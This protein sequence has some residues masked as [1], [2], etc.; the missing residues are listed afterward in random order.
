MRQSDFRRPRNVTAAPFL[1]PRENSFLLSVVIPCM[2][3]EEVL[4]RTVQQLVSALECG[5]LRFELIFVDDGSTDST[6]EILRELQ[7]EDPRIRIVRLSRNFGH[8]VAITAGLEHAIG[9]A[10][11]IIDADLQDPPDVLLTFI[12]KWVDGYDVVYGVRADRDGETAFKLW[13]AKLFYRLISRLSDTRIPLDTGDFRL[14]DRRVVDAL[15][16]MPE[17]DRFVR[18]MVSWLGFSQIGVAYRRAARFAGATK[19]PLFKMLRFAADAIFS[20]S[21]IPLRLATWTGFFASGLA[22]FGILF[23]IYSRIFGSGLVKGWTSTVIAILFLGGAQLVCLGIIG[24]YAGRIYGECKRRPLYVV[25][26]KIGFEMA[27]RMEARPLQAQAA[28]G[29]R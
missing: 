8:Q 28:M 1:Q 18:G 23:S 19:Y 11:A 4:P 26:E 5:A 10:V 25:R 9:D 6:P 15:L 14:M 12:K 29:K 3:E 16:S 21:T 7:T 20:F 13:T 22:I 27:N 17:R 24:E 2:N